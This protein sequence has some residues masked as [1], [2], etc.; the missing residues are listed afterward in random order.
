[1]GPYQPTPLPLLNGT[2]VIEQPCDLGTVT[3]KYAKAASEFVATA[4]SPFYLYAAFN[5][6]HAPNSA[7]AD[8]CGKSKRGAVGDSTM[9]TD[10]AIGQIM[11]AIRERDAQDGDNTLVL[12]TSDNGAPLGGDNQGNEPLRG[13]KAQLWEGGFR[14]PGIAWGKG[15]RQGLTQAVASTMDVHATLLRQAGVALPSDRAIDGIDLTDVLA[16]RSE[17]GHDC[18]AFYASPD[19]HNPSSAD[20]L[21]AVRCGNYKAYWKTTGVAPPGGRPGGLQDAPLMFDL[22][23]DPGENSPINETS[24]EYA[25]AMVRISAWKKDHLASIEWVT[26]QTA[27]GSDPSFAICANPN[28]NCTSTPEN[29]RPTS[30]CSVDACKQR[31]GLEKQC[32]S[33]LMV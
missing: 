1:M 12:F 22:V 7:G 13:G 25:S 31:Q 29:W 15:V 19:A 3:Q 20:A 10:W 33:S 17:Q 27:L 6:I 14:E 18:Y 21:S 9:E 16:G 24:T 32:A 8:F 30:V 2:T 4:K 28:G 11:N 23:T 5:H 26:A